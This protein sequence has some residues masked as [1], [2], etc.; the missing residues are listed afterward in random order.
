V[1]STSTASLDRNVKLPV[2]AREGVGYVWLVDPEA[3]T[4]E[5]HRLE[6]NRY[7]LLGMYEGTARLR[8]EPFEAL[9]LELA[10]LWG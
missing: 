5:V 9:E 1:L 2:Y 8:A 3:R 10:L 4:L 7:V 6:G